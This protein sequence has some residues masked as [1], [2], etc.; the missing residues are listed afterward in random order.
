MYPSESDLVWEMPALFLT[1]NEDAPG[2]EII[3]RHIA[4]TGAGKRGSIRRPPVA[5]R[6]GREQ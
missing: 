5:A 6:T 2:E 3:A 1:D 4:L